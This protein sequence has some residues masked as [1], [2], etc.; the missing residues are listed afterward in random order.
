M[1]AAFRVIGI[2][3]SMGQASKRQLALE[4]GAFGASQ[5]PFLGGKETL[6]FLVYTSF[7]QYN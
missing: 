5:S 2:A 7:N 6:E 1:G 3:N 4:A